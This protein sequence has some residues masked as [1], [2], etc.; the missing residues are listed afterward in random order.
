MLNEDP[1]NYFLGIVFTLFALAGEARANDVDDRGQRVAHLEKENARLVAERQQLAR[2]YDEKAASIASLKAQPPS[3]TRDRK[4]GGMLAE[5]KDMA[6]KLD[7]KDAELR[8]VAGVLLVE[9][10]GLLQAIDRELAGAPAPTAERAAA[11]SRR[12]A[13][14]VAA[15][16]GRPLKVP[17]W[18]IEA[19]DDAEDLS[20][21]AAALAQ[22]EQ[23]L[24][25]ERTRL[26]ARV[27][28]FRNQAKLA[29]SHKRLD[30]QDVFP[31]EEPRRGTGATGAQADRDPKGGTPTAENDSSESPPPTPPGSGGPVGFD[32]GEARL[33]LAA[34]PSVILAD[35]V[36]AGTLDEL[37]RAERSGDPE[38]MARAAERAGKEVEARAARLRALRVEMEQRA[39]KLRGEK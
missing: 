6:A 8:G 7:R 31:D 4:L 14:L 15:V 26:G 19:D 30:E 12:R 3:W 29:R 39:S 13:D 1:V 17:E 32:P 23:A 22:S 36:A 37:R 38:T 18:T 21:K 35:V 28:Y 34:D 33:N 25:S 2:V 5:S 10:R 27:V 16:S 11:L 24:L 9:R 20:Y